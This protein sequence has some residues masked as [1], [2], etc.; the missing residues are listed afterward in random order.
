M[1]SLEL[2]RLVLIGAHLM[3]CIPICISLPVLEHFCMMPLNVRTCLSTNP[4]DLA[5][6]CEVVVCLML[7]LLHTSFLHIVACCQ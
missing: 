3:C 5:Y 4:F 7:H 2:G 1:I 6:L